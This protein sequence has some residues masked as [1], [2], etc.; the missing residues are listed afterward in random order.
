MRERE[1]ERERFKLKK[2][3]C[4]LIQKIQNI[5]KSY[6]SHYGSPPKKN[7]PFISVTDINLFVNLFDFSFLYSNYFFFFSSNYCVYFN[8]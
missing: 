7:F 2:K 6:L 3:N 8:S 4:T 1:R 5:K